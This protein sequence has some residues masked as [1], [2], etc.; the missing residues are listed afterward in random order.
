M[1]DELK[2]VLNNTVSRR[3]YFVIAENAFINNPNYTMTEK[4]VFLS[5]CTYAGKGKSCFPGQ[6]GIAK[7]LG[8]ARETVSRTIKSLVKKNGLLVIYQITE[9]NRKT[10]NTYILADIDQQ[11]GEFVPES[12]DMF[13]CLT[14]EPKR[15]KGM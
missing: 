3:A 5:L 14:Q 12:L 8:I 7:N 2:E 13:R 9:S 11:T 4:I 1:N 15:I 6:N 10:V